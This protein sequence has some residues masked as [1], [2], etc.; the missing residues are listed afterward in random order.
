MGQQKLYTDEELQKFEKE[1]AK[2]QR[3]G[4]H[5]YNPATP[6]P[7]HNPQQVYPAQGH[8]VPIK[9]IVYISSLAAI[10]CCSSTTDCSREGSQA[11]RPRLRSLTISR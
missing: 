2:Q 5:A 11:S 8:Q 7:V 4:D 9:E 1:Y 3:W 10:K 6:V